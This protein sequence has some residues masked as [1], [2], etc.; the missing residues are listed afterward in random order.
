VATHGG[1]AVSNVIAREKATQL[2]SALA[3]N[4][5]IGL[6][7]GVLM[8][9]FKLTREQAFDLL[10]IVSQHTHRK[11]R[12]VATEVADTGTIELPDSLR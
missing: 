5:E 12:D 7:M 4:R 10:R 6:A 1:L 11:L 8:T 2:E 9:S 3:S